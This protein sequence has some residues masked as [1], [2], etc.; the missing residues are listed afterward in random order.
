MARLATSEEPEEPVAAVVELLRGREDLDMLAWYVI[1][2]VGRLLGWRGNHG[3]LTCCSGAALG[4]V[5][6]WEEAT[7][8]LHG[9][10]PDAL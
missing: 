5:D 10:E 1:G 6:T 3:A 9:T 2:I 8:G 7:S 4:A